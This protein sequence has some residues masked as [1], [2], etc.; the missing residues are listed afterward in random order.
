MDIIFKFPLVDDGINYKKG[1]KGQFLRDKKGFKKYDIIEG[2]KDLKTPYL[3]QELLNSDRRLS[4]VHLEFI[5][6][7]ILYKS[8]DLCDFFHRYCFTSLVC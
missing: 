2:E 3:L 4:F 7:L 5:H 6:F 1:K 8:L